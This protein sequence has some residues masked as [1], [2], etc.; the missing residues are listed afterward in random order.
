MDASKTVWM[1][2]I[3]STMNEQFIKKMFKS[4]SKTVLFNI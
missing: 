1:G 2:N 4:L 3:D